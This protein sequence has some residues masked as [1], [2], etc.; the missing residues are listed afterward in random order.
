VRQ[1]FFSGSFGGDLSK[2]NVG[3]RLEC[4]ICWY[5]YDPEVGDD[6]RQVAPGTGFAGLPE[7]WS[8]PNCSGA[9]SDFLVLED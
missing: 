1:G 2:I 7:D 3:S 5:V 9:K 8:C 4:K 6:T